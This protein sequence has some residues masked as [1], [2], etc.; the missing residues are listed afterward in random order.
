MF[1]V[2]DDGIGLKCRFYGFRL[3]I[4][5][6]TRA[7]GKRNVQLLRYMI[8]ADILKIVFIILGI[9]IIY[10]SY[11]LLAQALFPRLVENAS[12][13]Y[14]R[15]IRL[16]IIGLASALPPVVLG[17][18]LSKIPN[19]LLKFIGLTLMIVPGL[20]GL[21]GSAGLGFRFGLTGTSEK[22]VPSA[23]TGHGGRVP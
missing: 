3:R 14:G 21:I 1:D 4:Q 13:Q 9:L 2:Q 7:T 5:Q 18:V 6:Q 19:P 23:A 22:P 10:V 11:W 20:L 12:R 8:M 16:S 17:I 15:P